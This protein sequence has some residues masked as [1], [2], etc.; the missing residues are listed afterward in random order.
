MN[1]IIYGFRAHRF[2]TMN[3]SIDLPKDEWPMRRIQTETAPEKFSQTKSMLWS[4]EVLGFKKHSRAK[5]D[6]VSFYC[7]ILL[8]FKI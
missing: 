1:S 2:S 4:D 3:F 8:L 6:R 5:F 7:S